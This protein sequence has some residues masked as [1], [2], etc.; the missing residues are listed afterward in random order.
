MDNWDIL[1]NL[2]WKTREPITLFIKNNLNKFN[3]SQRQTISDCI[4]WS[5]DSQKDLERINLAE[6]DIAELLE[7]FTYRWGDLVTSFS[8]NEIKKLVNVRTFGYVIKTLRNILAH[9]KDTSKK[10]EY[11]GA[12]NLLFFLIAFKKFHKCLAYEK[13]NEEIDALI[14][15]AALDIVSMA[16]DKNENIQAFI[17]SKCNPVEQQWLREQVTTYVNF[18]SDEFRD[19]FANKT[20]DEVIVEDLGKVA[21]K[22]WDVLNNGGIDTTIHDFQDIFEINV[23]LIG[24]FRKL[25]LLLTKKNDYRISEIPD[26]LPEEKW[27]NLMEF[28]MTSQDLKSIPKKTIGDV[29]NGCYDR[30]VTLGDQFLEYYDYGK[31][32]NEIE[33]FEWAIE[34]TIASINFLNS[35]I[36]RFEDIEKGEMFLSKFYTESA[37]EEDSV[38]IDSNSYIESKIE[39]HPGE[40]PYTIWINKGT[41]SISL[42]WRQVAIAR[43]YVN[44][45]KN[46]VEGGTLGESQEGTKNSKPAIVL[47]DIGSPRLIVDKDEAELLMQFIYDLDEEEEE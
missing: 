20:V 10:A 45:I 46:F 22:I 26:I 15:D 34:L 41:A 6:Q 28:T 40:F 39:S 18:V 13:L 19:F 7:I 35:K 21:E 36:L 29:T 38:D 12:Q 44:E 47:P 8:K 31:Q 2:L 23:E 9:S 30:S 24:D 16:A 42:H 43:D 33:L 4:F 32:L 37:I 1:H 11:Y 25:V 17:D 5:D 3:N 27:I 14:A